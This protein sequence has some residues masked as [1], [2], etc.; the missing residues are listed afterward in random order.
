MVYAFLAYL[1]FK[2]IAGVSSNE[3]RKQQDLTATVMHHSG[4]QWV[5]GI[6]G[7]VVVII[8]VVLIAQGLRPRGAD[9][10]VAES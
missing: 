1:T 4:G 10:G 7:L 2:L 5:V 8:G 6:A 3:T 9:L